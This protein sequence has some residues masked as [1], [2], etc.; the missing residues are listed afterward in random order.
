[1]TQVNGE[2]S[3]FWHEF[4]NSAATWQT[5]GVTDIW[6]RALN[7]IT[8]PVSC[9]T[10]SPS[11]PPEASQF[12]YVIRTEGEGSAHKVAERRPEGRRP[13]EECRLRSYDNLHT[14]I[15]NVI[16]VFEW[17]SE[18]QTG[19]LCGTRA[20]WRNVPTSSTKCHNKD[21]ITPVDEINAPYVIRT[22]TKL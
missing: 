3:D 17:L 6:H 4:Q 15:H 2:N 11:F 1:M 20:G 12:C 22:N 9:L 5:A 18:P 7:L 19:F 13:L 21:F 14:Y 8:T 10:L 16:R